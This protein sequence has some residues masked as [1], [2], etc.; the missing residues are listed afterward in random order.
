[1]FSR[2]YHNYSGINKLIRGKQV[3]L[4]IGEE[5]TKAAFTA[6]LHTDNEKKMLVQTGKLF[7]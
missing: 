4:T 6:L 7:P 1:M 5:A 2:L 3:I